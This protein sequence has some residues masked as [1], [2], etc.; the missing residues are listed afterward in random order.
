MVMKK[1]S[2]ASTRQSHMSEKI[3]LEYQS[4]ILF[5]K[6]ASVGEDWKEE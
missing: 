1:P 4:D 3:K 2:P 6:C 5:Y